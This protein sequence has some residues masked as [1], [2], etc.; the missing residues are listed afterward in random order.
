MYDICGGRNI[1]EG[2]G[3]GTVGAHDKAMTTSSIMDI[4]GTWFNKFGKEQLKATSKDVQC[5]LKLNFNLVSIGKA[6]KECWKLS[7]DKEGLVL[8]KDSAKFVFNIK[9]M[10]KKRCNFLCIYVEKM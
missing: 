6:I 1:G 5:N 2:S 9:I 4:T 3:T 10:A 8:M 7:G